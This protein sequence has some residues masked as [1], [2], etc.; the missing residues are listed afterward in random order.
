MSVDPNSL[1]NVGTG[2]YREGTNEIALRDLWM[3][4]D[5]FTFADA[6]TGF[7]GVTPVSGA[8]SSGPRGGAQDREFAFFCLKGKASLAFS[9]TNIT[10]RV[11]NNYGGIGLILIDGQVPSTIA[12]LTRYAD[13]VEC[14]FPDGYGAEDKTS[15]DIA[16]AV[17]LAAGSHTLEIFCENASPSEFVLVGA[18]I[19]QADLAS[20]ALSAYLVSAA[21]GKNDT[22]ITLVNTWDLKIRNVSIVG[23]GDVVQPTTTTPIGTAAIGDIDAGVSVSFPFALNPGALA[24]GPAARALQLVAEYPDPTGSISYLDHGNFLPNNDFV[25]E[26]TWNFGTIPSGYVKGYDTAGYT[27]AGSKVLYLHQTDALDEPWYYYVKSGLIPVTPGDYCGLSVYSGAINT[28]CEIIFYLYQADGV[29]LATGEDAQSIAMTGSDYTNADAMTGGTSLAQFKRLFLK[30]Q[31]PANCAYIK[32]YLGKKHTMTGTESWGFFT[33]PMF[34]IIPLSQTTP[35]DYTTSVLYVN[36]TS[37]TEDIDIDYTLLGVPPFAVQNIRIEN[38]R[39]AWDAPNLALVD[40]DVPRNNSEIVRQDAFVRF[41]LP[42]D[43]IDGNWAVQQAYDI[44]VVSIEYTSRAEIAALQAQGIIVLGY[45][46][47]GEETG[48]DVDPFN[49]VSTRAPFQGDGT[50]PGGYASYFLK[51]QWPKA[52]GA[53]SSYHHVEAT[54]C[55]HDKRRLFDLKSCAQ[56]RAEYATAT[57]DSNPDWNRTQPHV[58]NTPFNNTRCGCACW[59]DYYFGGLA[60]STG[61]QCLGGYTKLN[62]WLRDDYAACANAACPGYNPIN[63]GCPLYENALNNYEP[64]ELQGVF[65]WEAGADFEATTNFPDC[66]SWGFSYSPS[67]YVPNHDDPA[68]RQRLID[69]YGRW[70]LELPVEYTENHTLIA[71]SGNGAAELVFQVLNHPFENDTTPLVTSLDGTF[72]YNEGDDYSPGQQNGTINM[73]A[74]AGQ[75]RGGPVLQA[76]G[77]LR[78]TYMSKGAGCDGVMMDTTG[79]TSYVSAAFRQGWGDTVEAFKTAYPDKLLAP[80][81]GYDLIDYIYKNINFVLWESNLI[82]RDSDTTW[83]APEIGDYVLN[84]LQ[85]LMDARKKYVFDVWSENYCP[86]TPEYAA[87]R[88]Y[89]LDTSYAWGFMSTT[90]REASVLPEALTT[91]FQGPVMSTEWRSITSTP[92]DLAEDVARSITGGGDPA[93]LVPANGPVANPFFSS[94][95]LV[96]VVRNV[97]LIAG[98]EVMT[99][100]EECK[101]IFFRVP[102]RSLPLDRTDLILPRSGRVL[103]AAFADL[104]AFR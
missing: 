29:T 5:D 12:G 23:P 57:S 70:T 82:S 85:L 98:V 50:G 95:L 37:V 31:I 36:Y 47:F 66:A 32:V 100:L 93:S 24:P 21:T 81:K 26:A 97:S 54:E 22:A 63:Q 78:I 53:Q 68:W 92:A 65:T 15:Y 48:F 51:S 99:P 16:V 40:L 60:Q 41:P 71:Y 96:A 94:I 2:T 39:I 9:G 89:A 67:N 20:Y 72:I 27:I 55:T 91:S 69:Y 43:N 80:N 45:I 6:F 104:Q 79:A 3:D 10:L 90:G 62:N 42:Y 56:A 74:A 38:G 87:L 35:S 73:F 17:G 102:C 101:R 49:Y 103:P 30:C 75:D 34:E 77:Q 44:L 46:S 13:Q 76:G 59:N 18:K 88:Q 14:A 83:V 86:N 52:G 7:D 64:P 58:A 4:T 84:R 11:S 61:E 28:N 25:S 19:M 33:H 8:W 1:L